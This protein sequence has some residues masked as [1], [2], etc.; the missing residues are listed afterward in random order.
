MAAQTRA[1]RPAAGAGFGWTDLTMVAVV[2]IWGANFSVTKIA[3]QEI[4]PL[5][6]AGARFVIAS[7]LLWAV[8]RAVEGPQRLP[9]GSL[10]R[11]I[12]LGIIGNSFYQLCFLLGLTYTT[13]ANASLIIST[14]P[15]MV[16]AVGALLGI[17]RLRRSGA[18]GI[19]L[20]LGGV[21]LILAARGLQ[22]TGA[23]LRGDL[24]LLG[25]A[26]SWTIYTLGV[27]S[28][29]GGLSP[30][31]I[32][33][34]TTITGTPGLVLIGLPQALS[35][36][37]GGLSR[38]AWGGLAYSAVLG[39]V[40]AYLLW[41]NSVRVAGPNKT[42]IFGCAIPLVATLLAWPVLGEAPTWAQAAGAA[43]IVTGVLLTRR[44]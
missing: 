22:L 24:L 10:R 35:T 4:P 26:V 30:L 20:A 29:G 40:L 28:L 33:T 44:Q 5:A 39:V 38:G 2:L 32:T 37:W 16:A 19:A 25:C 31:T 42:A 7:A 43:L 6:F 3:L 11:L 36:D 9:R 1:A 41:N 34:W 8:L 17:E 27:R 21:G 18:A 12:W 13:A 15:A 23:G 14:T